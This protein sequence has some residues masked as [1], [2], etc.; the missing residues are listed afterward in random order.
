MRSLVLIDASGREIPLTNAPIALGSA[1]ECALQLDGS[2]APRHVQLT[3]EKIEA[4]ADCVVGGVP[5]K[6]GRSRLLLGDTI[7]H[8]GG[9]KLRIEER[10]ELEGLSTRRLAFVLVE[11]LAPER[12]MPAVIV[13]EGLR[14]DLGRPLVLEDG[15]E[16][17]L[18]RS[19]KCDLVL[20][21]GA[22]S[23][24]HLVIQR[25]GDQ[26]FIRDDG[27]MSGTF[28]G[29]ARLELHRRAIWRPEY[30]IRVGDTVVGLRMPCHQ[31]ALEA[32][33]CEPPPAPVV[34]TAAP[35]AAPEEPPSL[36]APIP[37]ETS[38]AP[39]T[40]PEA[41]A[42]GAPT[43]VARSATRWRTVDIALFAACGFIGIAAAA[44]L[45]Y[46]LL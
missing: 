39:A 23:R 11:L 15:G 24:E 41:P 3:A 14:R 16:Y 22:I 1:D 28:L 45:V 26:I 17:V 37:P 9:N 25:R 34:E 18:G 32:A 19:S 21:D 4:L 42:R 20:D 36:E 10:W 33:M 7:L 40:I 5:L 46:I 31:E 6:A 2:A 44:F 30:M 27:S 8:V 35:N 13:V 43:P 38:G 29:T 12:A